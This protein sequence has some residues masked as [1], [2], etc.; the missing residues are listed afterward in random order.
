MADRVVFD[1]SFLLPIFSR[2]LCR[3]PEDPETGRPI[4]EYHERIDYCFEQLVSSKAKILVPTPV[5]SEIL[6]R[7]ELVE[8]YLERIRSESIFR[9]VPFRM[10]AAIEVALMSRQSIEQGHENNDPREA[11]QKV[12]FDRQI[13][14]IAKVNNA[15]TVYTDDKQQ[16][17]FAER[18]GLNV[19]SSHELPFPPKL[20]PIF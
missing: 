6:V 3:A 2:D 1:S 5:L 13:I 8:E 9:V 20:L 10:D 12:K 17:S 7:A 11:R 16:R 4:E 15:K 19:I 18:N 14:A